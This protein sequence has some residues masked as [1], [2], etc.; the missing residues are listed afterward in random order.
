M[1][2]LVSPSLILS[3]ID[4][5]CMLTNALGKQAM[6]RYEMLHLTEED[7]KLAPPVGITTHRSNLFRLNYTSCSVGCT[8]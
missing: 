8:S 1:D 4:C 7:H 2:S 5:T 6:A 3:L